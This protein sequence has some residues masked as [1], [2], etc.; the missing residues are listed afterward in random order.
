MGRSIRLKLGAGFATI[1][2]V[3]GVA[4]VATIVAT[5]SASDNVTKVNSIYLPAA[6]QTSL[7]MPPP[8]ASR[9]I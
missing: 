6:R 7:P 8:G 1:F 3:M 2:L 4:S 9:A 5:V